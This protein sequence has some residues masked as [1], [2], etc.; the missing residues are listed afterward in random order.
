MKGRDRQR[1]GGEVRGIREGG[2]GRERRREMNARR[3]GRKKALRMENVGRKRDRNRRE[4][5]K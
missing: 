5:I 3:D 4:Q 2:R 1:E